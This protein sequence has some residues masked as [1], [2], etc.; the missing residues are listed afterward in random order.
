MT[1]IEILLAVIVV[2]ILILA[3]LT[4][5]KMRNTEW[6]AK[7][8][9]DAADPTKATSAIKVRKVNGIVWCL[10]YDGIECMRFPTLEAA[11]KFIPEEDKVKPIILN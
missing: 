8:E 10:S 11:R 2:L 6:M 7:T 5:H 4:W 3:A 9:G 1:S